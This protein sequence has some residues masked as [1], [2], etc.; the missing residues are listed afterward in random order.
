LQDYERDQ[1]LLVKDNLIQHQ[2]VWEARDESNLE[3]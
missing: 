3:D 2:G 1:V